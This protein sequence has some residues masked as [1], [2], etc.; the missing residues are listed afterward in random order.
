MCGCNGTMELFLRYAGS[1]GKYD[2][3]T[4]SVLGPA[5][6]LSRRW[7]EPLDGPRCRKETNDILK[8]LSRVCELSGVE[9]ETRKQVVCARPRE[10]LN[11]YFDPAS[12]EVLAP[13][14]IRHVS[15]GKE[16]RSSR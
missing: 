15:Y 12:F 14:S 13:R 5:G 9:K 7:R 1:K 3:S 8:D 4:S 10:G 6:G 11:F 2:V 16:T